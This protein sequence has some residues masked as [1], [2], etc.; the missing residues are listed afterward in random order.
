MVSMSPPKA[1]SQTKRPTSPRGTQRNAYTPASVADVA[2]ELFKHFGY[3]AT[4][5]DLVAAKLDVTKAA[6]YYHH[7]GKEA[8]LTFG[9][10]RALRQL[11]GVLDESPARSPQSTALQRFEYVLRRAM[12]IGLNRHNEVAVL[13]RLRGN[14]DLESSMVERR[15]A[16]DHAA[17]HLLDEAIEAGELAPDTDSSLLTRLV[18]GLIISTVEWFRPDGTHNLEELVELTVQ[19]AMRGMP[20][21]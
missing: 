3:D 15:R 7:N 13:Y 16:F 14:S 10:D 12:S 9:I 4:S 20:R 6:L 17:A 8:I 2:F 1:P 19:Y 5:L 21:A 11:E 18:M